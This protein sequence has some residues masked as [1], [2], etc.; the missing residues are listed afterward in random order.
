M[1][2]SCYGTFIL[3]YFFLKTVQVPCKMKLQMHTVNP[4]LFV[5]EDIHALNIRVNKFSRVP[6]E[7]ILTR[8]FC[9]AE[10][11]VY[12]SRE[13]C[14]AEI[15]VYATISYVYIF[16]MLQKQLNAVRSMQCV[17]HCNRGKH[18]HTKIILNR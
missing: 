15:T 7:N 4:E 8:E 11:T 16:I 6:N 10:I 2:T 5:Y 18:A 1:C 9:Q 12:V 13:F 3:P 14:Q 17:T